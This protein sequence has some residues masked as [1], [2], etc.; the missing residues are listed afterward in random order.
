MFSDTSTSDPDLVIQL[1]KSEQHEKSLSL[2]QL[3]SYKT[4][5]DYLRQSRFVLYMKWKDL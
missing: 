3:F 2:L 1:G 4:Y 5:Q